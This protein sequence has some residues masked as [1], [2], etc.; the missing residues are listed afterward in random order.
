MPPNFLAAMRK[1]TQLARAQDAGA[2][3]RL[4]QEVLGRSRGAPGDGGPA[5]QSQPGR[6]TPRLTGLARSASEEGKITGP[7][8]PV[9]QGPDAVDA[10]ATD[11]SAEPPPSA[12]EDFSAASDEDG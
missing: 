2:A 11:E 12:D 3:T 5:A 6:D 10:S 8:H 1:A 7:N 9:D 4:I